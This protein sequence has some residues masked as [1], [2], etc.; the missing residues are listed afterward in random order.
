MKERHP[1]TLAL[2]CL[3]AISLITGSTAAT[4]VI[5]QQSREADIVSSARSYRE[6]NEHRILG[7]FLEFLRIPN[8]AADL[9]NIRINAEWLMRAM[10]ARGIKTQLDR[11]SVV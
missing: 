7:E 1:R 4:A 9:P 6:A 10:E 3:L 2:H 8:V 5:P 11:K